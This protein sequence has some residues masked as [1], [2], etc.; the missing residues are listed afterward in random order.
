[1]ADDVA[2]A[3]AVQPDHIQIQSNRVSCGLASKKYSFYITFVITLQ[4][5]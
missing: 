2:E 3:S 1:M 5:T 4:V